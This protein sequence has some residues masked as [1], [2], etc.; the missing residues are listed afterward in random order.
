VDGKLKGYTALTWAAEQGYEKMVDFLISKGANV[1]ARQDSDV[2]NGATVLMRAAIKGK[3]N[4]VKKLVQNKVKVNDKNR[5][6]STA[7]M[8]A[9][10]QV[11]SKLSNSYFKMVQ[12]SMLQIIT[13]T[14]H[15]TKLPKLV[16]TPLSNFLSIT[17]KQ[18]ILTQKQLK[19]S[20]HST[21]LLKK[22]ILL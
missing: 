13:T 10:P 20:R 9:L 8:Q 21:G 4:I 15:C 3:I 14:H 1:N 12:M 6:N 7:L 16:M 5:F 18:T 22:V 11:T 19:A 17:K 2:N